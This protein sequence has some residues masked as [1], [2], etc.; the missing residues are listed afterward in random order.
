VSRC[1]VRDASARHAP[2]L[3]G[4]CSLRAWCPGDTGP[5]H[6]RPRD[7]AGRNAH[8][9][10]SASGDRT[11]GHET[12]PDPGNNGGA[13][14]IGEGLHRS[15]GAGVSSLLAHA[16]MPL[17]DDGHHDSPCAVFIAVLRHLDIAVSAPVQCVF[18]CVCTGRTFWKV[19]GQPCGGHGVLLWQEGKCTGFTWKFCRLARTQSMR[20]PP[21]AFV[22]EMEELHNPSWY[23]LLCTPPLILP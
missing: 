13:E 6:G 9:H 17:L 1:P 7:C 16:L 22:A 23:R 10:S 18:V 20:V 4:A 11:L 8:A 3:C 2:H 21:S 12:P 14:Q 19:D 5:C 15:W